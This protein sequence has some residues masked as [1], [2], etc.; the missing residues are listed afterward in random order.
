MMKAPKPI[1]ITQ[2]RG[3]PTHIPHPRQTV[4]LIT[5]TT[6]TLIVTIILYLLNSEPFE[7][8]TRPV[9]EDTTIKIRH[10]SSLPEV[11]LITDSYV[12]HHLHSQET[13]HN[14]GQEEILLTIMVKSVDV[15][16]AAK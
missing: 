10:D 8:T 12:I 9:Q 11:L 4:V 2:L 1:S 3:T 5:I 6:I 14:Q 13:I 15:L 7:S 16:Y